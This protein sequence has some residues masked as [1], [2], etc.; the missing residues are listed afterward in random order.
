MKGKPYLDGINYISVGDETTRD[1]AMESGEGDVAVFSS[2][3]YI[4]RFSGPDY[5]IK[6]PP[7]SG[8]LSLIPDTANADSPWANQKVREAVEYAIDKEGIARAFGHGLTQAPYQIVPPACTLAY[9]PDFKIGRKFDLEKAKQLIAEAGGGFETSIIVSPTADKNIVTSIQGN[10]GKIGIK[11][12]LEYTEIGSWVAK[13]AAP[14]ANWHNAALYMG[15]PTISGVDFAAGLQFVFN[16]LGQSWLRTPEMTQ[17]YQDFF[18]APT[19]DIQ[20][21]RAVTDMI[22]KN[23][24]IIPVNESIAQFTVTKPNVVATLF[25]R[26]SEVLFNAEDWWFK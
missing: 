9:N 7:A 1:L 11:V 6:I 23:A 5:I 20:K 18:T 19:I 21:I 12:N 2:L 14:N 22:I 3:L 25:E 8:I 16:N 4:D 10:L 15:I 17:A 26:T 13:Y 24:A